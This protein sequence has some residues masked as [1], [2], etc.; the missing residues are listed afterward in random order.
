MITFNYYRYKITG[1]YCKKKTP[2]HPNEYLCILVPALLFL[3][4][5]GTLFAQ[6]F[7]SR[8]SLTLKGNLVRLGTN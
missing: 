3:Y 5:S 8:I 1:I 4:I 7:S 6:I 2:P